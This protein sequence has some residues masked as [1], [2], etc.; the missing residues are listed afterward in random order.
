MGW[1]IP[2]ISRPGRV[3]V[4]RPGVPD[5]CLHISVEGEY[6]LVVAAV[7][8]AGVSDI[9]EP[10]TAECAGDQV[11]DGGIGIGL[12]PGADLLEILAEGLVPH[13]MLAVLDGPVA[14]GVGGQVAGTGQVRGQAGDA[15]G[16]LL[17]RPRAA[18]GARVAADTQDLGGVRPIDA[19]GRG[20]ADGPPL[21]AAVPCA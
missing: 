5:V 20:G 11:A 4:M 19:I 8:A 15:V 7:V 1:D 16:D 10:G 2:L 14:A 13:V 12:V 9:R 6:A 21:A 3:C 18:G 17:V